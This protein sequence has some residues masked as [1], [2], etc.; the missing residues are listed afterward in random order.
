MKIVVV[1]VGGIG[2]ILAARLLRL[3]GGADVDVTVV[4]GNL[5]ISAAIVEH[6]LRVIEVDGTHWSAASPRAPLTALGPDD[7]PFDLCVA[8]TKITTLRAALT[9]TLPRL[10]ADAQVVC[11][12]NGLPEEIA[13]SIV[14]PARAVGC[15]VGWG[16]SMIEPG[17][18]QRTSLGGLQLERGGVAADVLGRIEDTVITEDFTGT[19]WS[20]LAINCATSTL[21]AIGGARLGP[22]MRRRFVRRLVLEIWTEVAAVARASGVKLAPV[23][24]TLDIGRMALT[25][26]ER[27]APLGSP[28]LAW[29]H[30]ILVGVGVKYRRMRSSMLYAIE[31]GRTP[32]IDFL[33]GEVVTRGARHGVPTP[34]NARLVAAVHDIAGGR[35]SPSIK[36]LRG[37]FDEI[38]EAVARTDAA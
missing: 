1:G 10:A 18:Y 12:Q 33:N 38:S 13:A 5:A 6:G 30:S 20:K 16:A 3:G 8:A 23:S 7:G 25:D 19:R 28:A 2:G 4:T 22:L 35:A 11:I 24:G 29:K 21:G 27:K 26:R 15:V 9:D 34:V 32:E 17:V 37:I 36:Y 31:R 14:G